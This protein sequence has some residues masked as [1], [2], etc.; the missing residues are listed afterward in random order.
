MPESS[1][2]AAAEG[3]EME[4]EKEEAEEKTSV[5]VVG[6]D[7]KEDAHVEGKVTA[8]KTSE[9]ERE[10]KTAKVSQQNSGER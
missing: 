3:A 5:D 4:E 10:A 8:E 9:E 2:S 7:G 6:M 1:A